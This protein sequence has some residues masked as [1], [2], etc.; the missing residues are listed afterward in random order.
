MKKIIKHPLIW[1]TALVL[2][3]LFFFVLLPTSAA[4]YGHAGYNNYNRRPAMGF[5]VPV[6]YYGGVQRR[7]IREGSTTGPRG[8]GGGFSGGK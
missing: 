4:G 2:I 6:Q 5:F 1:G 7:S 8:V 3:G